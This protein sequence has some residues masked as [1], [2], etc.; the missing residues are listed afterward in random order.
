MGKLRASLGFRVS[1]GFSLGFT[2]DRR[3][4]FRTS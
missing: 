3:G 2:R 4:Q 1:V